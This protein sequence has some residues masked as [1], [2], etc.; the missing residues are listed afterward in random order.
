MDDRAFRQQAAADASLRWNNLLPGLQASTILGQRNRQEATFC[1]LCHGVDHTRPQC[2]LAYLHPP[3][4]RSLP[5]AYP[6]GIRRRQDNICFSWNRGTCTYPGTCF[7]RHVC[8]TCQLP[9][10]AKDCPRTH[11]NSVFKQPQQQRGP[12]YPSATPQAPPMTTRP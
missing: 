3:P 5:A 7:Y 10:K 6:P 2:A 8:A 9:H 1:T 12:S 11:E 4:V